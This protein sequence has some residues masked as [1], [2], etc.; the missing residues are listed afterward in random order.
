MSN[1]AKQEITVL[2]KNLKA[3]DK[4]TQDEIMKILY[5]ELRGFAR[6]IFYIGTYKTKRK[7]LLAIMNLLKSL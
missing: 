2:L 6:N 5:H 1:T 7:D 3:G 4:S